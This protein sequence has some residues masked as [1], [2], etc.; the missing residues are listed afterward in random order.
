[1]SNLHG[2]V[3]QNFLLNDGIEDASLYCRELI[4][5]TIIYEYNSE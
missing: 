4:K 1:M 3:H 2:T 5:K